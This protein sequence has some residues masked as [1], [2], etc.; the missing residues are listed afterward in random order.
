[1]SQQRD[2]QWLTIQPEIRAYY[3]SRQDNLVVPVFAW[4]GFIDRVKRSRQQFRP[5]SISYSVLFGIGITALLSIAPLL[6][7]DANLWIVAIYAIA[8]ATSILVGVGL[9]FMERQL[10]KYQASDIDQLASEMMQIRD[11]RIGDVAAS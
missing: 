2:H 11:E 6:I 5:W 1:M 10:T 4:N 7:A 8:A 9:I 3:S